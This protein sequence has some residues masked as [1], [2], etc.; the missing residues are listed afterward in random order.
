M[1][2]LWEAIKEAIHLIVSLD[3]EVLQIALRTLRLALTSCAIS[4]LICL[5]LGSLIH[6]KQFRGKRWLTTM[7]QTMFSLPTVTIGLLV[8]IIFSR[9][10]PLGGF[11]FFLTPTAI[12]IGQTILIAPIMLG[13]IISALSGVDKA[14]PETAISLGA[15][16]YQM[17]ITTFRE[18]RYA[19]IAAIIMGFGRAV[20][21]VGV[22]NIV[23]G[24]IRGY[25]GTLSTAMM[26]ETQ[27]G[28]TELALA[29]GLILVAIALVINIALYRL[30]YNPMKLDN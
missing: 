4:A 30:Q 23:G 9:S 26:L 10:G 8:Y 19:I 25:T 16:R 13:L 15:S 7:I 18:A 17:V 5:P 27:Q 28:E 3:D 21:E 14:I 20:T 2:S 29:L 22:S 11:E 6:F 12:V 1:P 24:N